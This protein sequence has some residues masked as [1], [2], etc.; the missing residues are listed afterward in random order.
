MKTIKFE[1]LNWTKPSTGLKLIWNCWKGVSVNGGSIAFRWALNDHR[2]IPRF[3]VQDRSLLLFPTVDDGDVSNECQSNYHASSISVFFS[4]FS[5][6]HTRIKSPVSVHLVYIIP[7]TL[8][9][10][11]VIWNHLSNVSPGSLICVILS[12]YF[13]QSDLL[14]YTVLNEFFWIKCAHCDNCNRRVRT[15]E[16]CICTGRASSQGHFEQFA[17]CATCRTEFLRG[18]KNSSVGCS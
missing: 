4:S 3:Q 7:R 6:F 18:G 11:R 2:I 5:F 17:V 15:S 10:I 16:I 13:I 14:C 8:E 12:K 1:L 9:R